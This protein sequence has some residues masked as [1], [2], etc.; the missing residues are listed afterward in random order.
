MSTSPDSILNIYYIINKTD[1]NMQ[2]Y[3][4]CCITQ[5]SLC[6]L[7]LTSTRENPIKRTIMF[8]PC[9]GQ[10]FFRHISDFLYYSC[11]KGCRVNHSS[12][13]S[14]I[15]HLPPQEEKQLHDISEGWGIG[16]LS[17]TTNPSARKCSIKKCLRLISPV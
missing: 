7:Y 2:S 4:N 10:N 17:T 1:S 16:Y 8:C 5:K 12:S 11:T 13:G 3:A 6:L 9:T 15:L 14:I